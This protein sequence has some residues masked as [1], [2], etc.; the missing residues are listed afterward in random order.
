M[1]IELIK[2]NGVTVGWD[3]VPENTDDNLK[4]GTIRNMQFFGMD[5]TEVKYDGM[6][7][8]NNYVT[9]IKYRT[10]GFVNQKEAERK[11]AQK[12]RLGL[13]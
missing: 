3:L 13:S 11:A 6:E 12:L 7:S 4:L 9:L 8:E 5:D 2:E 1:K 10:Q